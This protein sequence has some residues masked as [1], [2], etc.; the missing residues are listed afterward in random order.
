M[1]YQKP[2]DGLSHK[3]KIIREYIEV[4]GHWLKKN[5]LLNYHS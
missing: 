4:E 2:H 3:V 1:S 5:V